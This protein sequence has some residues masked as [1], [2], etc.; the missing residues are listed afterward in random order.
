MSGNPRLPWAKKHLS[1]KRW[2]EGWAHPLAIEMESRPAGLTQSCAAAHHK[3]WGDV[4][5]CAFARRRR[6]HGSS[7]VSLHLGES[8]P[9]GCWASSFTAEVFLW[10]ALKLTDMLPKHPQTL[11]CCVRKGEIFHTVTMWCCWDFSGLTPFHYPKTCSRVNSVVPTGMRGVC[12]SVCQPWWTGDLPSDGDS[13]EWLQQTAGGCAAT[14]TLFLTRPVSR[15]G[16]GG[17]KIETLNRW[18]HEIIVFNFYNEGKHCLL[19]LLEEA[20]AKCSGKALPC[21]QLHAETRL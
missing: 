19:S 1:A 15:R 18:R 12:L 10:S 11:V 14:N 5:F 8:L 21:I 9:A 13:W 20:V 6:G 7:P 16:T 3:G 17:I 4:S 2:D